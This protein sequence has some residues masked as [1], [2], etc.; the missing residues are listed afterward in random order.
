MSKTCVKHADT[1]VYG[2]WPG[3]AQGVTSFKMAFTK[4]FTEAFKTAFTTAF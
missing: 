1:R 4:A 3:D 2:A